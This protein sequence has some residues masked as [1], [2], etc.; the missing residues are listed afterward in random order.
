VKIVKPAVIALVAVASLALTGCN[1]KSET[2]ASASPTASPSPSK[3]VS[4]TEA[5]TSAASLL[6]G[7]PYKFSAKGGDGNTYEGSDDPL[8]GIA[9]TKM[10]G[11][12]DAGVNATLDAQLTPNDYYV[13]ITGLPVPGLDTSKWIHLDPT[14][15]KVLD[16]ISFGGPTDPTGLQSLVKALGT[17]ERT[18]DKQ[19]KGTFDFTKGTW[20]G[21]V[22]ADAVTGLGDKAKSV[23][24]EATTDDKGRLTTLKVTVP[25]YGST[26]ED[27]TTITYSDFGT[28]VKLTPPAAA[29]VIEAPEAVYTLINSV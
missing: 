1:N 18:G 6:R 10:S 5:F 27:V 14:K 2:G 12:L 20:G 25:A 4:P 22:G 26:K 7:T 24:F 29:E 9:I 15:V 13:K 21:V 17:V 23:P 16:L 11:P 19:F 8:A 3:S 28:P